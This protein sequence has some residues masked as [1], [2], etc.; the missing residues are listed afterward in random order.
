MS[1]PLHLDRSHYSHSFCLAPLHALRRFSPDGEEEGHGAEVVRSRLL[2]RLL[3]Q[4]V[5]LLLRRD[6]H[7]DQE[8]LDQF[9]ENHEILIH[10]SMRLRPR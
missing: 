2:E 8:G 5:H 4:L 6:P 7:S 1:N 9:K 10:A 3:I